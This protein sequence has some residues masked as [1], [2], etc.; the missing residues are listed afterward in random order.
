M[1][2]VQIVPDFGLGGIQKAG[3][4]LAQGLAELGCSTTVIGLGGGPRFRNEGVVGGR[5][6]VCD[7]QASIVGRVEAVQPEVVHLHAP[8]YAEQL[9]TRL[10]LVCP[11][12]LVVSTP[13]F[14]RPPEDRALLRQTHTCTVGVYTFYRLRKWLGWSARDAVERGV[15]YVPLTP[16][17]PLKPSGTGEGGNR[18]DAVLLA[19]QKLDLDEGG[20]FVGR[21]GRATVSKWHPRSEELVN[22]VLAS[23][24][25]IRW[26]SVGMPESLGVARLSE[27]WGSRFINLPEMSD[28]NRLE[29]VIKSLDI[30]LFF[31]RHGECFAS[32]IAEAAGVGVPTIALSTPF[33]DNGQ[34]EQVIDG[35]TGYL[36]T[37]ISHATERVGQLYDHP[38]DLRELQARTAA[39]ALER[40]HYRRVA[41]DLLSLY[42]FWQGKAKPQPPPAYVATML[43]EEQ[44]FA[45]AYKARLGKLA[46]TSGA[47][48]VALRLGLSAY[49]NWTVFKAGR[50]I[51]SWS[52]RV[53]SANHAL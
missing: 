35:V 24:P 12:S 14:G 38:S 29:S 44:E 10:R 23:R 26:L 50:V 21:I 11:R 42:A 32:S 8:A 16:Y 5:H 48:A 1:K 31:S 3:C 25:T 17:F 20:F 47:S 9:V 13:V 22:R 51:K 18:T 49:E 19:R 39:H 40:W 37:N 43:S 6:V 15:G 53:A 7:D 4:V 41:S 2:C 27:R 28:P 33:N 30:Q 36:V 45:K 34:A 46:T 52:A